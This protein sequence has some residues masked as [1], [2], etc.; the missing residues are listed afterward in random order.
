MA[1]QLYY[2]LITDYG[3]GAMQ[4]ASFL[5]QQ[6]EISH[7][8]IG[9]GA[10]GL[11]EPQG[12]QKTLKNEVYRGQLNHVYVDPDNSA[13][14]VFECVI[15]QTSGGYTIR[16]AGLFD[17]DGNL[18]AIAKVAETVKPKLEEGAAK[19]LYIRLIL[20]LSNTEEVTIKIDPSIVLATQKWV[21]ELFAPIS[22]ISDFENPHN[23]SLEQVILQ[24]DDPSTTLAKYIDITQT[25][26][27]LPKVRVW[28]DCNN[29][30]DSN[31]G[32]TAETAVKT[33]EKAVS[34]GSKAV[35][36]EV[37]LLSDLVL[38]NLVYV[39][40]FFSLCGKDAN[41][42]GANRKLKSIGEA[43]NRKGYNAALHSNHQFSVRLSFLT[44]YTPSTNASGI[45]FPSFFINSA[46]VYLDASD[47]TFLGNATGNNL[48]H[49]NM[50]LALNFTRSTFSNMS[51]NWVNRVAAGTTVASQK[52][53]FCKH[54]STL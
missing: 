17:T 30:N 44:I 29:G 7:L 33:I 4:N 5:Q 11:Y 34:L 22:H 8:A 50:F 52:H 24:D 32:K 23:T 21:T 37:F 38:K 49:S 19:E 6:V 13:M 43:E 35:E 40:S 2:T 31:D 28:L 1:E 9:D 14:M 10:G 20:E 12:S 26:V 54:F 39:N 16:E 48:V 47:C 36:L 18:F 25:G 53:I 51:G 27:L 45:A 3:L 42:N 15:P 41:G 46:P